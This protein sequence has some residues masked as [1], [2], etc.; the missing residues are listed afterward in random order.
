MKTVPSHKGEK[1]DTFSSLRL[2]QTSPLTHSP[3][4]SLHSSL[5]LHLFPLTAPSFHI[6]ICFA[7]SSSLPPLSYPHLT[8]FI[9]SLSASIFH[10]FSLLLPLPIFL[11]QAPLSLTFYALPLP[12]FTL[13]LSLVYISLAVCLSSPFQSFHHSH[14]CS[15]NFLYHT[16][17]LPL[18]LL[19]S[20]PLP[21]RF[22]PSLTH[23]TSASLTP[24]FFLFSILPSPPFTH[25]YTL[26]APLS[27]FR[28][29]A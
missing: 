16:S 18:S 24:I 5:Y 17:S 7:A 6:A 22:I 26:S 3:Y 20:S 12:F 19:P 1:S 25:F 4:I 11:S 29:D 21:C 28:D 9:F 10:C 23:I 27:H 2:P 8:L 13:F 15:V 14:H